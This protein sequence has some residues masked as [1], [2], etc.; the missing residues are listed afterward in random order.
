MSR[1]S[2]A[3]II[4]KVKPSITQKDDRRGSGS[5][6]DF[7]LRGEPMQ[8]ASGVVQQL[9]KELARA[10]REV[11]P[12]GAAPVALGGS[13]SNRHRHT[14]SPAARRKISLAQKARWAEQKKQAEGARPK[15]TISAAGAQKIPG[16]QPCQ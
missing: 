12:Y 11:E 7:Q 9:K 2:S 10:K 8:N 13:Q 3:R 16:G 4:S 15:R 6:Y 14:L 5:C 1:S